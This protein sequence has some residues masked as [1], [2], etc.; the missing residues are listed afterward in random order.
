VCLFHTQYGQKESS[1][2]WVAIV[3]CLLP[4]GGQKAAI[5]EGDFFDDESLVVV[6]RAEDGVCYLKKQR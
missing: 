4:E 6:V 1:G 2:I 3:E 5:V